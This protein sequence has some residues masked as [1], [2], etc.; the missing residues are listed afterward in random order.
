MSSEE[1]DELAGV[2]ETI[3]YD[4]SHTY[5]VTAEPPEISILLEGADFST[6]HDAAITIF[7]NVLSEVIE[8]IGRFSPDYR[9]SARSFGLIPVCRGSAGALSWVLTPEAECQWARALSAIEGCIRRHAG[10]L[11]ASQFVDDLMSSSELE[12]DCVLARCGCNPPQLILIHRGALRDRPV[13]C[14]T[15]HQPYEAGA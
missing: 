8:E 15:C 14:K 11:L 7:V 5:D 12:D 13:I 3:W 10:L 9:Q 6:P 4:I 2:L 1:T